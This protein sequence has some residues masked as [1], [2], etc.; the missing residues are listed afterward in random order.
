M[1]S[2]IVKIIK[3]YYVQINLGEFGELKAVIA[4]K[5]ED[6]QICCREK[7]QNKNK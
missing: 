7:L 2:V 5:F 6:F 1:V 4:V 3:F